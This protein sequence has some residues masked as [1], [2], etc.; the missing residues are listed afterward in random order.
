MHTED[1]LSSLKGSI[2]IVGSGNPPGNFG[3]QIDGYDNVIRIHNIDLPTYAEKIGTKTT[4]ICCCGFNA[5]SWTKDLIKICPF[6][7]DSIEV[8]HILNYGEPDS[9]T[10]F[11]KTKAQINTG[12]EWPSTGVSLLWMFEKLGIKADVFLLDGCRTGHYYDPTIIE[13]YPPHDTQKERQ[14]LTKLTKLNFI[15]VDYAFRI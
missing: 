13:E 3:S 2:A 14:S 10:Y 1:V 11:S 6:E 8:K 7:K 15:G 12:L 5:D 9:I 4:L